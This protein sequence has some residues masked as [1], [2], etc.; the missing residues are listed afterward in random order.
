MALSQFEIANDLIGKA[1]KLMKQYR[2]SLIYQSG[3]AYKEKGDHK[4]P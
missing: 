2:L 4:K 3:L 1:L